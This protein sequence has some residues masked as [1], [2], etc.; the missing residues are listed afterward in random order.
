M[1]RACVLDFRGRWDDHLP[2][3]EFAYNNSYQVT[4][5]M[6]PYKALYGK[7]CRSALH[8]DEIGEKALVRPKLVHQAVKKVQVIQ[9]RVKA[10]QDRYNSYANKR[11]RPLEF[12]VGE[13][14]FL[15]VL[16]KKEL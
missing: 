16:P 6:P 8:W 10:T 13:H 1:L 11:M 12:D 9:Q 5:G 2:L 14:M 7:K 3:V 15:K 4:I